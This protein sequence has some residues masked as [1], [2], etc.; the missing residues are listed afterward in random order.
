MSLF[1]EWQEQQRQKPYADLPLR[2]REMLAVYGETPGKT[3]KTCLLLKHYHQGARWMKCSKS[4]QT[5]G[6]GTDWRAGWPACG[7]YQEDKDDVQ[8]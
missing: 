4:K 7:L 1:R 6:A 8:N 2:I 3:C 5:G